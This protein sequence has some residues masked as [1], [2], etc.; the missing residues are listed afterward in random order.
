MT[1]QSI[2]IGADGIDVEDI[3][4]QIRERAD[5]R[6][7]SGEFDQ[8]ELARA[9]RFNLFAVKDDTD[10][11][12]RYIRCV[13]LM[14]VVN[15]NDFEI[16]E[17]RARFAPILKKFKKAI[18]SVLKFYTYR[19]WSQQ[20]Q[21]NGLFTGAIDLVSQRDSE[22]LKKMQSRIDDLEARLAELEARK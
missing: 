14:A 7:E 6:R 9:E 17:H 1:E 4:R 3:V 2:K 10:L 22:Q 13:G 18:W 15:M 20:N 5:A 11:F 8:E 21:I 16:V 12:D 19:L